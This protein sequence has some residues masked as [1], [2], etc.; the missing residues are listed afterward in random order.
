MWIEGVQHS[1]TCF[2]K[3]V[4]KRKHWDLR[5]GG[6]GGLAVYMILSNARVKQVDEVLG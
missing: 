3:F 4:M 2:W 1:E 6:Q 5:R